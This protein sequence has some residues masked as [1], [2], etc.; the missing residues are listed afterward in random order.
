MADNLLNCDLKFSNKIFFALEIIHHPFQNYCAYITLNLEHSCHLIVLVCSLFA[1]LRGFLE[2][3]RVT[4]GTVQSCVNVLKDGHLLA[5]A[6]GKFYDIH[7]T[8]QTQCES[9]GVLQ[10]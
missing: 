8:S 5:I 1:G 2:V 4:P 10:V 3:F 6:P 7:F 9:R